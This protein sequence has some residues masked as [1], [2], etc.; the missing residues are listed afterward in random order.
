MRTLLSEKIPGNPV[1]CSPCARMLRHRR[2][3][4]ALTVTSPGQDSGVRA[5][6]SDIRKRSGEEHSAVE[7]QHHPGKNPTGLRWFQDFWRHFTV[8]FTAAVFAVEP[9]RT[10]KGVVS[11]RTILNYAN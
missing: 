11:H 5:S 8:G 9:S 1:S 7:R 6:M 10:E 2:H 4:A 3:C